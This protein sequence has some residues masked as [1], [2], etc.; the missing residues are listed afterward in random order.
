LDQKMSRARRNYLKALV[1]LAASV[2][3][4]STALGQGY[5]GPVVSPNSLDFGD[6]LV[7]TNSGAQ[8]V[9]VSTPLTEG[10]PALSIVSITLP[11]GYL[12]NGG[13]CP[14]SGAATSPCTVGVVFAPTGVGAVGGNMVVSAS[15]NGAPAQ[16]ANVALTGVG[17]QG[18]SA[19]SAPTLGD[20]GL[21]L[22]L[23]SLLTTGVVFARKR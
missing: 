2:S 1:I 12:R 17:I 19:V 3:V 20:W 21:G 4:T 6:V 13:T 22:L 7:G 18:V 8:T 23:A 9:T 10:F 14:A 16:S 5:A 15:I 11:G